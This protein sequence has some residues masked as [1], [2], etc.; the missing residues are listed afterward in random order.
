MLNAHTETPSNTNN[1]AGDVPFLSTEDMGKLW[2][3]T[4][5][6][7]AVQSLS[8]CV[9]KEKGP[10]LIREF[11]MKNV[12]AGSGTVTDIATSVPI[13]LCLPP[14]DYCWK[15]SANPSSPGTGSIPALAHPSISEQQ[16]RAASVPGAVELLP[17]VSRS[18]WSFPG[19]SLQHQR[20][21]LRGTVEQPEQKW[22]W[23]HFFCITTK[24]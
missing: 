19:L 22:L 15:I 23:L 5:R 10:F 4:D 13:L 21:K 2:G 3:K 17:K 8:K 20:Q 12:A 1:L 16:T 18:G 11:S 7:W 6:G 14:L 24:Y 9:L